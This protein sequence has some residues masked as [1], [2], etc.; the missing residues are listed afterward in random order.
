MRKVLLVATVQSH[1]CQFHRPLVE[2]LHKAGAIVHVAARDNLAQKNGL[3]LDFVEEVF[4]VPFQRSPFSLKNLRAY[5]QLKK[6][7]N[8]GNYDI[9]HCNTPVGGIVA[10]LAAKKARQR[11]TKVFYMAHGFH[12]YKGASLKNRLVYYPIEKHF[13]KLC[14][15]LITITNE[16]YKLASERFKTKVVHMHGVGVYEERYHDVPP[17]ERLEMRQKEKIKET[18]FL[19]ICTG[20]LNANK[21]QKTLISAVGKLKEKIPSI[22]LLLAG[23]G[24]LE[25]DLREQVEQEGLNDCVRF[26]GYRTDLEKVVPAVDLVVSCSHREGLPLNIIEAMLCKKP[27][28]AS[29]NRGHNELIE[30]NVNGYL[31]SA[32]DVDAFVDRIEAVYH[33]DEN[34]GLIGYQKAQ[35]YTVSAIRK[36]IQ[37]YIISCLL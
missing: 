19:I 25:Q 4:N 17:Y 37:E 5:K 13:A 27:V 32:T 34:F 21:N 33:C 28:I 7:I 20:E 8:N 35:A 22:K 11:G 16:D 30:N 6:I 31:V 24:P 15:V 29:H 26:L 36:E 18:D 1:I 10:R 23:N 12:F 2:E 9:V 3:R 14:D